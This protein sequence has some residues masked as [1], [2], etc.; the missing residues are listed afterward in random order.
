MW[1][2]SR[3]IKVRDAQ[4]LEGKPMDVEALA[5]LTPISTFLEA[6]DLQ[7]KGCIELEG[8]AECD[9]VLRVHVHARALFDAPLLFS[10]L[11]QNR[12][13]QRMP[14]LVVAPRVDCNWLPVSVR[15]RVSQ[16]V[17]ALVA[18]E[19]TPFSLQFPW[20]DV[21]SQHPAHVQF[22]RLRLG[23]VA[24]RRGCILFAEARFGKT[25]AALGLFSALPVAR[26]VVLV[27]DGAMKRYWQRM[28]TRFPPGCRV[29]VRTQPDAGTWVAQRV[30]FDSLESSML[31]NRNLSVQVLRLA[32]PSRVLVLSNENPMTTR[33]AARILDAPSLH[34]QF[35]VHTFSQLPSPMPAAF[36]IQVKLPV[37]VEPL[38]QLT[39]SKERCFLINAP[40]TVSL[41]MYAT[42]FPKTKSSRALARDDACA[43]CLANSVV[44]PVRTQ[45]CQQVLCLLCSAKLRKCPFC[46]TEPLRVDMVPCKIP[47]G[48]CKHNNALLPTNI[49][50]HLCAMRLWAAHAKPCC[51]TKIA[52]QKRVL[53]ISNFHSMLLNVKN[54]AIKQN[55]LCNWVETS[56]AKT[57]VT[58]MHAS[59][60]QLSVYIDAGIDFVVV[61]EPQC[62]VHKALQRMCAAHTHIVYIMS[63]IERHLLVV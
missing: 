60:V 1:I 41:D 53:V 15:K 62:V 24:D 9:D 23:N 17:R 59:D 18:R 8:I 2:G 34:R 28:L 12:A 52:R 54:T 44:C 25:F 35:I 10:W 16:A 21:Y 36:Y 31:E 26:T 20:H 13:V 46:R 42:P 61:M 55:L 30:V 5:R 58:L 48:F 11:H 37:E 45:C 3:A 29:D 47:T 4:A 40:H 32:K 51:V 49:K 27:R 6:C 22:G 19:L 50:Q 33:L 57:N 38:V 43:I 14:L 56:T 39:P 63:N 7:K